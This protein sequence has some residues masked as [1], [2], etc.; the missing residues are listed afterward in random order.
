ME[1]HKCVNCGMLPHLGDCESVLKAK[2]SALEREKNELE[3][4]LAEKEKESRKFIDLYQNKVRELES[5]FMDEKDLIA[6]LVFTESKLAG[7]EKELGIIKSRSCNSCFDIHVEEKNSLK[8]KLSASEAKLKESE[9]RRAEL[10]DLYTAP[11]EEKQD[12]CAY[13]DFDV[14]YNLFVCKDKL[15]KVE[16]KINYYEN[17]VKIFSGS[18]L[19]LESGI[20]VKICTPKTILTENEELK[21]KLVESEEKRKDRSRRFVNTLGELAY[22]YSLSRQVYLPYKTENEELRKEVETLK[23]ALE[24]IVDLTGEDDTEKKI[25]FSFIDIK[26][27]ARDALG[28]K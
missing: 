2:I 1:N 16:A 4:K 24:K 8:T 18:P 15:K 17:E 27:I 3:A 23:V 11:K 28:V 7:K 22:K 26:R 9:A 12:V 10:F 21:K 25:H 19:M 13:E 5:S 20:E 6:R 14:R